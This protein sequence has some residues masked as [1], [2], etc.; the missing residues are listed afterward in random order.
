VN[1]QMAVEYARRIVAAIPGWSADSIV[2]LTVEIQ[3]WHNLTCAEQAIHE[4]CTGWTENRRPTLGRVVQ[5]Y[6]DAMDVLRRR[7]AMR[8]PAVRYDDP[9]CPPARGFE[10]LERERQREKEANLRRP[11]GHPE[12]VEVSPIKGEM[13]F[14]FITKRAQEREQ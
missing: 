2:E 9:V 12:R 13:N 7:E 5:F 11:K 4:L 6:N 1:E 8:Q 10:V 3:T 14:D